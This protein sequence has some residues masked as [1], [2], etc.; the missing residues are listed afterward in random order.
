MPPNDPAVPAQAGV[1]VGG[2]A[3]PRVG[4]R[5]RRTPAR[6]ALGTAVLGRPA[7]I[8]TGSDSALPEHRTVEAYRDNT[9]RVLDAAVAAGVDWVDTARSYGRAEE[10][11]GQWWRER[12]AA[13]PDWARRAPTVSSKWG[14]AYVGD[15]NRDAPVHE[16]KDHSLP[17]FERQLALT[18]ATLP[19]LQLYQVHSLTLDSPLFDD[20]PLLDALARLRDSGVAVGFSTSGPGQGD[21]VLRA[22]GVWRAGAPLFSAVQSTWNLLETSASAALAVASRR[23]LTVMVKESLANGRLVTEPPPALCDVADRLGA[24]PDAVALAATAAQPWAT[25]VLIGPAGVDQLAAN[26][27]AAGVELTDDDLAALTAQPE[28]PATYWAERSAL[29]WR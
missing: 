2:S 20:G 29:P 7:Y 26:E 16:V 11:V 22:L 15:W 19:R 17:Q 25:R 1:V 23:E 5:R 18:R 28:D 6:L 3:L 10:F 27:R 21:T 24:S 12:A 13:D 8:N 14:Y 4:P 9:F